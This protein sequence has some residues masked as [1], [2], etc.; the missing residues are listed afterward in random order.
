MTVDIILEK[1]KIDIIRNKYYRQRNIKVDILETDDNIDEE[2]L[3]RKYSR[4]CVFWYFADKYLKEDNI[5]VDEETIK[6][7]QD[8]I[9]V[10]HKSELDKINITFSNNSY[11]KNEILSRIQ[12]YIWKNDN[13]GNPRKK[14]VKYVEL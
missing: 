11:L 4:N 8:I 12:Q 3:I 9:I 5:D 7:A 14:N 10:E 6:I 1:S 13:Y 2:D